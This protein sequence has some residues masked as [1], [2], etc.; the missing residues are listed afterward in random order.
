MPRSTI[1]LAMLAHNESQYMQTIYDNL[2][3]RIDAWCVVVNPTDHETADTCT[4]VFSS[5]P[6]K[7][8]KLPWSNDFAQARNQLISLAAKSKCDY[9][10]ILDPDTP[11]IGTIP[12]I[13]TDPLY[14]TRIEDSGT[15]WFMTILIR[16][17]T[18]SKYP[19]IGTVHETIDSGTL[20]IQVLPETI[21]KRSGTGGGLP[22]LKYVIRI[23][24]AQLKE[25]PT[26]SRAMFYLAQ[27][28]RDIKDHKN[29]ILW[30][31]RRVA[32][33]GW[34][35]EVYWSLLQIA[36]QT[37]TT[38]DYLKA[39]EFRPGR[40]EALHRLAGHAN[41]RNDHFSALMFSRMGL[42][43]Q[44]AP[45]TLFIEK[46]VLDYG[47]LL[48]Y[49]V[50]CWHTGEREEAYRIWDMLLAMDNLIPVHRDLVVANLKARDEERKL[51]KRQEANQRRRE[52]TAAKKA[53][54]NIKLL[55]QEVD[56][57]STSDDEVA[58]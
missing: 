40:I 53:R 36:D 37:Q 21:L 43:M 9:I 33:G 31:R 5:I 4:Q 19:Y 20:P 41:L 28:Y 17:K 14:G 34:D 38:D 44:Q 22:R 13:L 32:E 46:W 24:K 29:S 47:L 52:N 26:D 50:A 49:S 12:D 23:L 39:W 7:V 15:S 42:T 51:A 58:V 35:Q 1:C 57:A 8:H 18:R 48:E 3:S 6:G 30:Y 10:L 45:D 27:S 56:S 16:T 55:D 2:S 11:L 54:S 25:D